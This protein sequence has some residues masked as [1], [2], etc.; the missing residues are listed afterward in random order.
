MAASM[1]MCLQAHGHEHCDEDKV[2]KVMGAQPMQG[3]TWEQALACSQHYGMRG[4]LTS[5]CTLKQLKAWTDAGTPVIIAWNPE[6][7]EW[8]H[9]SV[10]FDVDDDGN[11]SVADPNIP[12]PDETVRV[13]PKSEFYSKWY[14]KWPDYLV[15]RPA[16]AIEREVTQD[17]RQ[18]Q[19][20]KKDLRSQK[21]RAMSRFLKKGPPTHEEESEAAQG[22]HSVLWKLRKEQGQAG[23]PGAGMG[24]GAHK[25]KSQYDRKREQR[26]DRDAT[27]T[28]P[29]MT[30]RDYGAAMSDSPMK[31][32]KNLPPDVECYVEEGKA[33]GLPEDQAWAVAWSRWCKYKKPG[34]EHCQ[35][36]PSEYFPG[37]KAKFERGVSM[38][39]D[40]VAEVVGPEF[41][42]MNE[43]PP[44][45]VIKVREKMEGKTATPLVAMDQFA[46]LLKDSKFEQGKSVPLSDLPKEL[47]ENVK[48]PPASVVKVREEMEGKAADLLTADD[49]ADSLKEGKFEK[50][51]PADPTENMSPE[52]AAEWKKQNEAH[53]DEFKAAGGEED[54]ALF[55]LFFNQEP[56]TA[57]M[58]ASGKYGFTKAVEAACTVGANKLQKAASRIAKELYGKDEGS[59]SFL[60]KHAAKG[61][62]KT[63][64]M[65]LKA[66]E[67]I[68]P[69]AGLG[70]TAG[71]TGNS[72]YGFSSKTAKLGLEAC[73]AL[74]HEAGEIACDTFARQDPM[75]VA[76]YLATHSKKAKCAYS[77]MLGECA[78]DIDPPVVASKK[79][80]SD[81]H[82]IIG[83]DV[84]AADG[85]NYGHRVLSYDEDTEDY[86]VQPIQWDTGKPKGDKTD[87]DQ[88]KISYRYDLKKARPPKKASDFLAA[89][90]STH[91]SFLSDEDAEATILAEIFGDATPKC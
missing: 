24:A 14:E 38:T 48:D 21:D 2:N 29:L 6:G 62:S 33:Q 67:G 79:A 23:M 76:A 20:G 25:D 5:P 64:A 91:P 58:K 63:A 54:G 11:V 35:K 42:E 15:R 51:K 46:D 81:P 28:Q 68:G 36:S 53:K 74:H 47:Q 50:D 37:R 71:K 65:L 8:S 87:I 44:S 27:L 45:S 32:A 77:A 55:N 16:M 70:K 56:R 39:V 7:R 12:D 69:M 19:A 83:K 80:S 73:S 9:A 84:P 26:V 90:E 34:D 82:G 43:D 52:D 4:T 49:F 10:V 30:R 31:T 13:V 61:G 17:G 72:L 59:P 86:I 41:K 1:A 40:E 88:F 66:M 3:A 60:A 22:M 85:S 78:P 89:D 18:V 75:K 57:A